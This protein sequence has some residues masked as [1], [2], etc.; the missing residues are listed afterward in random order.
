MENA[1]ERYATRYVPGETRYLEE[2]DP[3]ALAA[4]VLET[5]DLDQPRLL[6][7]DLTVGGF[8]GFRHG[9]P[10]A[11]RSLNGCPSRAC[12]GIKYRRAAHQCFR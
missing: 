10:R 1:R 9:A 6:R 11:A 2:V 8:L 3:E 7:R 5:I 4:I 12:P